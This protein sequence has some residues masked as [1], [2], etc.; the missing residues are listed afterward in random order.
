MVSHMLCWSCTLSYRD[1]EDTESVQTVGLVVAV[2]VKQK[3]A[4]C[5]GKSLHRCCCF[6]RQNGELRNANR[7]DSYRSCF[8]TRNTVQVNKEEEAYKPFVMFC[9]ISQAVCHVGCLFS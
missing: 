7:S 9:I 2:Q 8:P 3:R 4:G 5:G 6:Q 1:C